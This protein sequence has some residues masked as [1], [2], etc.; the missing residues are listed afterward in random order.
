MASHIFSHIGNICL[1]EDLICLIAPLEHHWNSSDITDSQCQSPQRASLCNSWI[2]TMERMEANSWQHSEALRRCLS[3]DGVC[4]E[5]ERNQCHYCL[6]CTFP[7]SQY[8]LVGKSP[9]LFVHHWL[10][11]EF[12]GFYRHC[13]AG[14]LKLSACTTVKTPQLCVPVAICWLWS[15]FGLTAQS[16]TISAILHYCIFFM[17]LV[18]DWR[19]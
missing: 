2:H 17:F 7:C 4:R 6:H 3:T 8:L 19:S 16:E 11:L 10:S 13:L 9:S 18:T 5:P 14:W 15:S 1:L 12:P